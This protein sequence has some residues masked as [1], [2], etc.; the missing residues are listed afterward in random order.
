MAIP[1]MSKV[2]NPSYA[3]ATEG[4]QKLKII[5]TLFFIVV[6]AFIL[7]VYKLGQIPPS[8][9]WDEAAMALD[10]KSISLTGKDQHGNFWLQP[11]YPSWGDYK[12]PGYILTAVPFF[13]LIKNNPDLAV[14]LPSALA[15][16]L[17][18]LVIFF[19]TKEILQQLSISQSANWRILISLTASFLLAVSPWHLQFSR[20]AFE[21]N[22][23]LL[24]ISLCILFF[25]KSGQKS[26]WIILAIFSCLAPI[27][28]YYS[29]RIILPL[30]LLTIF[31]FFWPKSLKNFLVF[32]ITLIVITG[33][34]LPLYLSPLT[35]QA[36]QFRLSTKSVINNENLIKYSSSLIIQDNYTFWSKKIHHR[37]LYMAKDLITHYF[38]HF[39][40]NFLVL[41][42]DANL[43]HSTGKIGVLLII[44]FL[45]FILGEYYLIIQNKR[46]FT[47]LNL[48]LLLSFLPACMTYEVPHALRSLNAVIFINI[49]SALGLVYLTK[50][51]KNNKKTILLITL[52]LLLFTQFVF[53]LHYYYKHYPARSLQWWQ[54]GYKQA[55]EMVS[56]NYQADHI[57]FTNFY[58]RPY[59]YFLLYSN[60][61]LLDFQKQ[62]QSFLDENFLDYHETLK[63][64]KIEFRRPEINDL[65]QDKTLIIAAPQELLQNTVKQINPTFVI[66]KNF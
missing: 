9:Y 11:I 56:K 22:L 49:I 44:G 47:F 24:F 35:K 17:T 46:L 65:I 36:E 62:R 19:L 12:L 48:L 55:V 3:K 13:K 32:L 41:S 23:A 63:I 66:W 21:A 60:Y 18:V 7:R 45:G 57:I 15:G 54:A 6:L 59:V 1:I 39:S 31:I 5:L 4:K 51:L 20:A 64:D 10:A 43:R 28:T 30:I 34:C 8:L 2:K 16:T 42:G 40:L 52:Y 14:R 27:Y 33:L 61:S 37:F 26:R 25:I 58:S 38:D 53:Y 50:L 29:A